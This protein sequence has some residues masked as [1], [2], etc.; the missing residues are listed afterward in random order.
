MARRGE[1]TAGESDADV[2]WWCLRHSTVEQGPSCP[3]KVKL[4][5]FGSHDEAAN[6]LKLVKRR[7]EAWDSE[8]DDAG[9]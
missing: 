4:G 7:N 9:S 2:F 1:Q 3:G 6:A 8:Q 5:P